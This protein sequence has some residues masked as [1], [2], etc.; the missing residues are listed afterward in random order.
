M[1]VKSILKKYRLKLTAEAVVKA[2]AFGAIFGFVA[3]LCFEFTAWMYGYKEYWLGLIAFFGITI[4]TGAAAFFLKFRP[5]AKKVAQRLDE[6]GLEERVITMTEFEN[7]QSEIYRMQREETV[8]TLKNNGIT[9]KIL[10]IV[11]SLPCLICLIVSA[12]FGIGM[13]TVSALAAAGIIEDGSSVIGGLVNSGEKKKYEVSYEVYSGNGDI[14]GEIFQVVEEGSSA[15]PVI[16]IPEDG[17]AFVNWSDG[18]E[19]PFRLDKNIRA[20]FTCYAVFM[21][22]ADKNGDGDVPGEGDEPDDLPV[23]YKK[24]GNPGEED[25]SGKP[26][27]GAGGVYENN[28]QVFD[29]ETYYGGQVYKNAY[30]D[31]IERMAEEQGWTDE[32][33][34]LINEYFKTIA[35]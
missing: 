29:G 10:K 20:N 16:A 24:G 27:P 23:D 8:K 30:S 11:L 33:K 4:I 12:T 26:S 32:E 19:N 1:E 25:E 15:T 18:S 7:E 31:A 9:E 13:T 5:S 14:L 34:E 6:L 28:N 3:L 35:K 22:I 2:A 21:P 17:Y